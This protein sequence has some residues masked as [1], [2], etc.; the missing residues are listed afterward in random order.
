[1]SYL[2]KF[3][4]ENC[5]M[6]GGLVPDVRRF[7]AVLVFGACFGVFWVLRFLQSSCVLLHIL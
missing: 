7:G 3:D 6:A 2:R 4:V 1:M 5:G